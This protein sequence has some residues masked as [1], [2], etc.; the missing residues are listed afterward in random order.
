M[1]DRMPRSGGATIAPAWLI[2][3]MMVRMAAPSGRASVPPAPTVDAFDLS[4]LDVAELD[5][6]GASAAQAPAVTPA[7]APL[8]PALATGLA[9]L[10]AMAALRVGRRVYRRR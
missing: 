9:G 8:P 4:S 6:P 1:C 7:V 5:E 10:A 3:L 2:A